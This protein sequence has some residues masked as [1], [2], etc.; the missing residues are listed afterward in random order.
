MT[1]HT[2]QSCKNSTALR[3]AVGDSGEDRDG[4]GGGGGDEDDDYDDEKL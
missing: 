2:H 3:W 1:F 4:G